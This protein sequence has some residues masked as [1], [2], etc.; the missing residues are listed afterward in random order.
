MLLAGLAHPGYW[1]IA[2]VKSDT[3]M[4]RIIAQGFTPLGRAT[5]QDL[6]AQI[7]QVAQKAEALEHKIFG[8]DRFR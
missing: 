5:D 4:P 1:R 7:Y 8:G 6:A 2:M 3:D